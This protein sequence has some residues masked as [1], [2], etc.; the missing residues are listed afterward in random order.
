MRSASPVVPSFDVV[1]RRP[2]DRRG[3]GGG[4]RGGLRRLG[5]RGGGQEGAERGQQ[6]DLH[7][8][9]AVLGEGNRL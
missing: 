3:I 9:F 1:Q 5:V 2:P 6:Q 4:G 8:T 7:G